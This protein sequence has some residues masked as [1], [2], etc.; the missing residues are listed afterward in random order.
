MIL[1]QE[2]F[3]SCPEKMIRASC[4]QSGVGMIVSLIMKPF[5]TAGTWSIW[6][7]KGILKKKTSLYI[8][9]KITF[10]R[11]KGNPHIHS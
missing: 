10:I 8:E 9:D 6:A 2:W 5:K 3:H 1:K 11:R 4:F 7:F